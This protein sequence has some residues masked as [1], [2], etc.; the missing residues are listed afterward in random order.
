MNLLGLVILA[1]LI[2]LSYSYIEDYFKENILDNE[3]RGK[4]ECLKGAIT[5]VID[6]DTIEIDGD[7]IRLALIDT[8]EFNEPGYQ[9][10]IDFIEEIC[11]G[12]SVV[13]DED[14]GQSE[15]SFGR[16]VGVVLCDD[17]NV[18][19]ALLE[20]GHAILLEEFCEVSEFGLDDWA[21]RN[22]C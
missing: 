18:N 12:K 10:A 17:I 21:Q 8:P 20:N 7:I 6:G 4:S 16:I 14:D 2:F 9:E 3:C 5:K 15:G 13:V 22:G 1:G 11:E 19:D